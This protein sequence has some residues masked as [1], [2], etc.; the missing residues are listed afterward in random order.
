MV[1]LAISGHAES[2]NSSG[3]VN[4]S[5]C[6]QDAAIWYPDIP[7]SEFS[8]FGVSAQQTRTPLQA[9]MFSDFTGSHLPHV[10]GIKV[11][12]CW[13]CDREV[14]LSLRVDLDEPL[15]G[16][17]KVDLGLNLRP[18]ERTMEPLQR[19]EDVVEHSFSISSAD[20]ERIIGLDVTYLYGDLMGFEVCPHHESDD[21]SSNATD[22]KPIKVHTNLN[23]TAQL[24]PYHKNDFRRSDLRSIRLWPQ[25]GHIVGF[26]GTVVRF[27]SILSG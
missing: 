9:K 5:L 25:T 19:N 16:Q 11:H 21:G 3:D 20:G 17:T 6:L 18:K 23:R 12:T 7:C 27:T 13:H 10:I 14:L 4:H 15:H 1:S 8:F 2:V 22:R 26:Y 24:P